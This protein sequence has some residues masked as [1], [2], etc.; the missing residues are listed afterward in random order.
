MLLHVSI[1]VGIAISLGAFLFMI[2]IVISTLLHGNPVEGYPS[3]L[4]I[5]LFVSGIQLILLG[6]IGEYIGKLVDE[7]NGRPVYLI[8][9][10]NIE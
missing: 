8:S 5:I 1:W 6:V 7:S 9:D 4:S 10:T 2:Y 3:M